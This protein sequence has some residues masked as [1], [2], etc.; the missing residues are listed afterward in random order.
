[1]A[2][3]SGSDDGGFRLNTNTTVS[4]GLVIALAGT[5]VG[6]SLKVGSLM[7]K[8]TTLETRLGNVEKL[9]D[10]NIRLAVLDQRVTSLER[11]QENEGIK[12]RDDRSARPALPGDH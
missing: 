8:I 10:M 3:R 5:L 9:T 12:P 1:M 7:E 11:R 4:I 6:G 2:P